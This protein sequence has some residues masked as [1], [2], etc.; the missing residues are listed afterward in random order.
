[1]EYA[2][3]HTDVV[4]VAFAK[5]C[6]VR[7]ATLRRMFFFK[8]S[9]S[10]V[11]Y[12]GQTSILSVVLCHIWRGVILTVNKNIVVSFQNAYSWLPG[13]FFSRIEAIYGD[14]LVPASWTKEHVWECPMASKHKAIA[15]KSMLGWTHLLGMVPV[16]AFQAS[17]EAINTKFL[18]LWACL[19]PCEPYLADDRNHLTA[20]LASG[21][22][23]SS[24]IIGFELFNIRYGLLATRLSQTCK[25]DVCMA[26]FSNVRVFW[27]YVALECLPAVSTNQINRHSDRWRLKMQSWVFDLEIGGE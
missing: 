8:A 4:A 3:A 13:K 26:L 27:L 1:M 11:P 18:I 12:K 21:E 6:K 16:R 20:I 5:V 17:P 10:E 9:H 23:C 24:F 15:L 25:P 7:L 19:Y 22:R 2:L 14:W